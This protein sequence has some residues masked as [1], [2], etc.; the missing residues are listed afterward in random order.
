MKKA[1]LIFVFLFVLPLIADGATDDTSTADTEDGVIFKEPFK[2]ELRDG[3]S[4]LREA[5]ANW[6]ITDDALE[7]KMEPLPGDGARNILFRKPPKKADGPFVV[8]VEIKALQP[9]TQQFQQAG[10]YWM[11]GDEL[12]FK[13]VMEN[14]DEQ[15]YVFPGKKPLTTEHVVLRWRID[16]TRLVAEYQPGATGEFLK[17]FEEQLPERDDTQDRISI[18]CWHG[19][20]DAEAWIRFRKF[21]ITKP[22]SE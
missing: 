10:L 12:K 1:S 17:A 2:K 9:Y 13:Y 18:Q 16:G 19:P 21:A 5:P 22:Q 15:L 7:L 14:I 8:T 6:R 3:W 11:Q 20:A 4:W